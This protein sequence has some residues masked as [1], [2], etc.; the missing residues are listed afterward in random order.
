MLSRLLLCGCSSA[1]AGAGLLKCCFL[2]A[3]G[4]FDGRVTKILYGIMVAYS[5][6]LLDGCLSISEYHGI[7]KQCMH[8]LDTILPSYR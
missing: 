6:F 2:R 8:N 7:E 1:V 3:G 4:W 5:V